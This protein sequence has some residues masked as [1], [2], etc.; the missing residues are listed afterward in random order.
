MKTDSVSLQELLFSHLYYI[1][2]QSLKEISETTGVSITTVSRRLSEANRKNYIRET[3]IIT[4]PDEYKESFFKHIT[5]SVI[6]KTLTKAF[7]I[8][9]AGLRQVIVVAG[10]KDPRKEVPDTPDTNFVRARRV[11]GHAAQLFAE[12]LKA[13]LAKNES[14]IN[15]GVN[16]GHGVQWVCKYFYDC[17]DEEL[18]STPGARLALSGL[19][20]LFGVDSDAK[21]PKL[22]ELARQ[23]WEVSSAANIQ[24]MANV[25]SDAENIPVR[26]VRVPAF[27]NDEIFKE[28]KDSR[29]TQEFL[30]RVYQADPGYFRLYGTKP[31]APTTHMAQEFLERRMDAFFTDQSEQYKDSFV[32]KYGNILNHDIILTGMSALEDSAG[33]VQFL[34][35]EF[36]PDTFKIFRERYDAFGDVAS[37]IFTKRGEIPRRGE[38]EIGDLNSRALSLWPE[39]LRDVA[40]IHRQGDCQEGGVIVVSSGHEKAEPLC[41]AL[42]K[43][44][45]ANYLVIDTNMA[46]K[47][48]DWLRIDPAVKE[49][50]FNTCRF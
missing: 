5:F 23:S 6:G 26:L 40:D 44:N 36:S 13:L 35:P 50:D 33:L 25:F 2:K 37:H 16:W 3:C 17:C 18:R 29:D 11:A 15:I 43:L 24:A 30:A 1:E 49:A 42:T 47:M 10:D 12:Q 7:N 4:P 21:E 45:I 20:G 34:A 9:K 39:D 41:I 32:L 48:Y 14:I 28:V 38:S 19:T 22:R 46:W 8:Q 27:L 31:V